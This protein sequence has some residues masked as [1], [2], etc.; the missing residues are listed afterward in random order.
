MTSNPLDLL[1]RLNQVAAAI[2]RAAFSPEADLAATARLVAEAAVELSAAAGAA[3]WL[4]T[5]DGRSLEPEPIGV[6]ALDAAGALDLAMVRSLAARSLTHGAEAAEPA[7]VGEAA[8]QVRCYPLLAADRP[9]AVLCLALREASAGPGLDP[10]AQ[11]ALANLANQAGMALHQAR[12]LRQVQRSLARTEEELER[13]R[14]ADLLIS[15]RL[16]LRDTLEAILQMALEVTG[17]RYGIF[18]LVDKSGRK[19]ISAAVAGEGLRQPAV[20]ALP[21]NTTSIMGWVAKHRR[22][23]LIPD[24]QANPWNRIYYPLDHG[25]AMRSELAVP[26]IGAG[27]RL[28]GVLNLESPEVAAFSEQDRHLLQALATQ[29]VIA[30]QEVR[31]LDAL[32][33]VAERLLSQPPQ[34]VFDH[35]V[36]L[37]CDLLNVPVANIWVLDESGEHL[38]L[39]AANAGYRRGERIPLA[40]SLTGEAMLSRRPVVSEDVRT[41]LRFQRRDLARAQGWRSALVAPLAA[42]A[43]AVPVGAFIVI[44]SE[45]DERSF[46]ESEWD[47]KVLTCLAHHAALAVQEARRREALRQAE[48]QRALAETFAAMGDIAANLLHRV[49]NKVGTIPVRVEGIQDKCA[50]LVQGEPYLAANLEEIRRSAE[51]AMA[52]MRESLDHLRPI[53]LQPVSVAASLADALASHPLPAGVALRSEGLEALPPVMAGARRLALVFANLLENAAT[54]MEGR[55]VITV[56]GVRRGPWVEVAVSDTGPGIPPE[57]HERIFDFNFSGRKVH[58]GK[59]GF[60]LW[61]VRTLTARFGGSVAVESDGQHGATFLLR[62]PVAEGAG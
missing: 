22:P 37:A 36:D 35:L 17:A 41:D 8:L 33:E 46:A 16:N 31:L 58:A 18:R 23:L 44:A 13:L 29:A 21:I 1:H 56:R 52:V 9:V 11:A 49:N 27:G 2:N 4:T 19:L 48:E 5:A 51:E 32:Q 3:V 14:R 59:L 45:G 53:N 38:V 24:L 43:D 42:G 34:A 15:S 30:I 25:L 61:W 62:L 28:E 39:Q 50:A 7:A 47:K 6:G 55:G 10:L 26:L 60:G 57:L 20:E 54:A 40:G 12:Q